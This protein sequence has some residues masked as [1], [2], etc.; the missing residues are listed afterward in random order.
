MLKD[1]NYFVISIGDVAAC[2]YTDV[3][4][5]VEPGIVIG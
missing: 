3:N 5:P 1:G 2:R 4:I